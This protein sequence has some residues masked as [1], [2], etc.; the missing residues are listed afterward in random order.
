MDEID[1]QVIP[2]IEEKLW[3]RIFQEYKI[4]LDVLI[5]DTTNFFN[6]LIVA[7]NSGISY[8]TDGFPVSPRWG[9]AYDA[10]EV[11]QVGI[12]PVGLPFIANVQPQEE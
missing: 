8:H 11:A 6:L 3:E 9:E 12:I 4:P 10:G 7:C 1:V 2:K 5:Y